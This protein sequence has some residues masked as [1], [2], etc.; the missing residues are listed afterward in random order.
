MTA[1]PILLQIKYARVAV[2][3]AK[4][5]WL[6]LDAAPDLCCRSETDRLTSEG[7]SNLQRMSGADLPSSGS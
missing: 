3:F 5:G 2:T 6:T 4:K 1:N 7:V